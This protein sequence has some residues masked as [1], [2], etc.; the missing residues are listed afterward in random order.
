LIGTYPLPPAVAQENRLKPRLSRL[1]TD[2]RNIGGAAR[3]IGLVWEVE[4]LRQARGHLLQ[5][6]P[7]APPYGAARKAA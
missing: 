3:P 4:T 1:F 2:T 5:D 7:A 6:R